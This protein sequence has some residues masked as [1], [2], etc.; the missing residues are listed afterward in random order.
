MIFRRIRS[1]HILSLNGYPA[2]AHVMLRDVKDRCIFLS[3]VF[4][5]HVTYS[6]LNGITNTEPTNL[7]AHALQA[8][9]RKKRMQLEKVPS[10][11]W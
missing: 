5:E 4:Q 11:S 2:P 6:E 1:A 7:D 3:A 10:R 8:Y 9:R